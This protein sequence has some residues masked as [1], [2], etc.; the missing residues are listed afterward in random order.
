MSAPR[1]RAA[2]V[3]LLIVDD[4]ELIRLGLSALLAAEAGA[5]QLLQA[6]TLAQ[7]LEVYAAQRDGIALVL[8]D[9]Q[10]PDAHGLSALHDFLARFPQAPV[11]VLSGNTDPG[12]MRQAIG[13]GA[14]AYFS[15]TDS[16]SEVARFVQKLERQQQHASAPEIAANDPVTVSQNRLIQSANGKR[17]RL[18]QR[19]AELLDYVLS[20]QSNREIAERLNLSEGTVKNQVSALLL[21]FGV[22]SRA[23]LISQ[24]R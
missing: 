2:A 14:L 8:L 12:L 10:L 19:R 23:Q 3:Q 4:H 22:R 16:F 9:L 20:G 17:V 5:P 18:S 11:A 21:L 1:K 7:A 6:N 24:L 15:K 13:D